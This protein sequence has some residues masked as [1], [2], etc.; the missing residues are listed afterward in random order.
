MQDRILDICKVFKMTD[1]ELCKKSH[2]LKNRLPVLISFP[3]AVAS[4]GLLLF[5]VVS[6]AYD[7]AMYD[8]DLFGKMQTFP[9]FDAAKY[10]QQELLEAVSAMQALKADNQLGQNEWLEVSG[11]TIITTGLFVPQGLF[12]ERCSGLISLTPVSFNSLIVPEVLEEVTVFHLLPIVVNESIIRDYSGIG[13]VD[14]AGGMEIFD[15]FMPAREA[16]LNQPPFNR[17][18]FEV[19]EV[20]IAIHD[21]WLHAEEIAFI[22]TAAYVGDA[23]GLLWGTLLDLDQFE[24][25]IERKISDS[26][27]WLEIEDGQTTTIK[28]YEI[29][30]R[31]NKFNFASPNDLPEVLQFAI[32]G[33]LGNVPIYHIIHVY[34]RASEVADRRVR[35]NWSEEMTE[36]DITLDNDKFVYVR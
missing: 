5:F 12:D 28:G 22:G 21:G 19:A 17:L 1:R 13:G 10:S 4:V 14:S 32:P 20:R 26:A 31:A 30:Y 2:R 3:V 27:F 8:L 7:F 25:D 23:R 33:R 9:E 29:F 36:I 18:T 15:G 24:S 6:F 34:G 35:T 16:P 11:D